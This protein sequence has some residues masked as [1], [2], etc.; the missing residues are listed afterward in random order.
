MGLHTSDM[1]LGTSDPRLPARQWLYG[2]YLGKF[3]VHLV[4]I[5][6]THSPLIR[7]QGVHICLLRVGICL[8]LQDT[9]DLPGTSG[10]Y[11]QRN[12]A[13]MTADWLSAI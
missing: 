5:S 1:R 4:V 7:A 13:G 10:C 12:L 6:D 3:S 2:A 9:V 8:Y 11:E